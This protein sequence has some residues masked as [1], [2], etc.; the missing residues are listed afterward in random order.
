MLGRRWGDPPAHRTSIMGVPYS[1][2]PIRFSEI[3]NPIWLARTEITNEQIEGIFPMR[4]RDTN[5]PSDTHP[6]SNASWGDARRFCSRLSVLFGLVVGLPT[7]VEWEYAARS[8]TDTEFCF[9]SDP[10]DLHLYAWFRNRSS[11]IYRPRPVGLLAPN[12]W[13]FYD[14]HGNVLEW[15]NEPWEPYR[16]NE[17]HGPRTVQTALSALGVVRGGGAAYPPECCRSARRFRTDKGLPPRQLG[18]RPVLRLEQTPLKSAQPLRGH[19]RDG[20]SM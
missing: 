6:V 15:C 17:A 12:G 18:F 20:G 10:S 1:E 19:Q 8:G 5:S 11:T 14:M 9:G 13:G 2:C 3:P 16:G 4:K 7:E